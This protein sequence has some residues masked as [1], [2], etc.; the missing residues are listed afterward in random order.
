MTEDHTDKVSL[1]KR[2][3]TIEKRLLASAAYSAEYGNGGVI[4]LHQVA[5]Q[6]I[7]DLKTALERVSAETDGLKKSR[8]GLLRESQRETVFQTHRAEAAE[9]RVRELDEVLNQ[10]TDSAVGSELATSRMWRQRALNA[11]SELSSA[12]STIAQLRAEKGHREEEFNAFLHSTE[13]TLIKRFKDERDSA[14]SEV[15][16]LK[17]ELLECQKALL[18]SHASIASLREATVKRLNEWLDYH[19]NKYRGVHVCRQ[20]R[21]SIELLRRI[22]SEKERPS[23]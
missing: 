10:K 2:A 13:G 21:E 9:A 4:E 19:G 18:D 6:V 5:A 12:Q 23:K 11:E 15:A 16:S 7:S 3:E 14:L 17:T 1:L 20:C 22:L 8:A